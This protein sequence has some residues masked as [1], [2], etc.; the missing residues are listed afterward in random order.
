MLNPLPKPPA[1]SNQPLGN[2]VAEWASRETFNE[3]V[4]VQVPLAGSYSSALARKPELLTPPATSTRPFASSVAVWP[5]RGA[6]NGPVAVQ[7]PVPG[8]YNSALDSLPPP[9][10]VASV[11]PTTRTLP[12]RNKV[13]VCS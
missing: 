8:S 10:S 1:T 6:D 2:K 3:P 7:A 13:I 5:C 11:P 9:P 4:F 12:F